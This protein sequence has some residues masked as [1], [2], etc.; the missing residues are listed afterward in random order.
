MLSAQILGRFKCG[1]CHNL[2]INITLTVANAEV[3]GYKAGIFQ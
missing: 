1:T 3:G 2:K